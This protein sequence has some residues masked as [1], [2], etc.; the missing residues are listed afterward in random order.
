[1]FASMA[2]TSPPTT[3]FAFFPTNGGDTTPV[4][5]NT[6]TTNPSPPDFKTTFLVPVTGTISDLTVRVDITATATTNPNFTFTVYQSPSTIGIS[7]PLGSWTAT[8]LSVSTGTLPMTTGSSVTATFQNTTN[9]PAVTAGTLLTVVISS[10]GFI[11]GDIQPGSFSVS[12][13]Y[14]P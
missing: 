8:T 14:I 7:A 4:T 2:L 13:I 1:M 5:F 10:T 3:T 12:Y 6:A 11:A 9:A